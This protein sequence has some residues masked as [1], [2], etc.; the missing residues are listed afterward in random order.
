MNGKRIYGTKVD[1]DIEH[2][3][4]FYNNRAKAIKNMANPYVS[5]LLGDQNPEYALAWDAYE[6]ENILPKMQIDEHSK[7]LDIGCGMGR[8][9]EVLIPGSGYYCGTDLS[10]EMVKC[11]EERNR[12]PDKSYDFLNY[13]FEE[14]CA[15]PDSKLPCRF[16]R[17]WICGIMMYVNDDAL[18]TGMERLLSKMDTQTKVYFTET[19]ALEER[20]TLNQF[21]SEA[22]KADYDV[23]YRTESEYNQ[24]YESWLN[25]GFQ[26]REQGMLPHLNKEKEYSET[27]RWYTILER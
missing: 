1:I 3:Q 21:Y 26:I 16:N 10:S 4:H 25:A 5:V 20:L 23:I 11:A 12:F 7:V 17:L 2:T 18:I 15:L 8:W 19:I 14:F 9:A 24:V 27:D 13:G 6:K 22:L